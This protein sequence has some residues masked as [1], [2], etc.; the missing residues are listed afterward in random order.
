MSELACSH[1][2]AGLELMSWGGSPVNILPTMAAL[3]GRWTIPPLTLASSILLQ[4][5]QLEL[6]PMAFTGVA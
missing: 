1:S 6:V 3:H 4:V 2:S 5:H